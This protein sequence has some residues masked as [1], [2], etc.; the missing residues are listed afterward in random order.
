MRHF[1]GASFFSRITLVATILA[2]ALVGEAI[3]RALAPDSMSCAQSGKT[4]ASG[5]ITCDQSQTCPGS[6]SCSRKK[7]EEQQLTNP[8][9]TVK[10]FQCSC[11]GSVYGVCS[12]RDRWISYEGGEDVFDNIYCYTSSPCGGSQSCFA[13]TDFTCSCQ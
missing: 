1:G 6:D 2:C 10:V 7:V 3:G 12:A 9:R 11:D 5:K 4:N 13:N 8:T